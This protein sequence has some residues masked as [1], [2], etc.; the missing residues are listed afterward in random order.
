M[1]EKSM[2]VIWLLFFGLVLA[3]FTLATTSIANASEIENVIREVAVEEGFDPNLAVAIAKV[4][5]RLNPNAKGSKGEVGLFQL[6][7]EYHRIGDMRS[8]VRTAIRY[9][10]DL[11][12]THTSKYGDA[13]FIAYNLGPNYDKPIRYPTLFK[14]YV[15]VMAEMN[16]LAKAD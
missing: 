8:N 4:E 2:L 1:G 9:L 11:Q 16:K 3:F 14:Y 12:V 10:K 7:P 15:K 5:S 6:R 13:W